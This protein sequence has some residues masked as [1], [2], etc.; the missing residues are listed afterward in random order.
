MF[1]SPGNLESLTPNPSK[2]KYVKP[3]FFSELELKRIATQLR[4]ERILAKINKPSPI[5]ILQKPFNS[6]L[7]SISD[8]SFDQKTKMEE[9]EDRGM[10]KEE[11]IKR[12]EKEEAG[13]KKEDEKEISEWKILN[14]GNM[15]FSPHSLTP[16]PSSS[17]S[18]PPKVSEW[19]EERRMVGN[20]KDGKGE[21]EPERIEEK[22]KN[23]GQNEE[24][25][26][27]ENLK[28]KKKN[29]KEEGEERHEEKVNEEKKD[30][31]EDEQKKSQYFFLEFKGEDRKVIEN[32]EKRIET[33]RQVREIN[34]L[35]SKSKIQR[36]KVIKDKRVFNNIILEENET[37][38]NEIP[39]EKLKRQKESNLPQKICIEHQ[40]KEKIDSNCLKYNKN[41]D[42]NTNN[43]DNQE[44]SF[45]K[46]K[47][48]KTKKY[49]QSKEINKKFFERFLEEN[50]E[51]INY[52][53][54]PLEEKKMEENHKKEKLKK[55]RKVRTMSKYFRSKSGFFQKFYLY[56][57]L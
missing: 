38:G 53:N 14:E 42:E 28:E 29:E 46:K 26:E 32:L 41:N 52:L 48:S 49:L 47:Y 51:I 37:E 35:G 45:D 10:I 40:L 54:E 15:L 2:R 43:F 5:K 21:E 57:L 4:K 31:R 17:F 8:F 25:N 19:E 27:E 20:E 30:K 23:E 22:K 3:Q 34:E 55:E 39:E 44:G 18:L 9:E 16:L 6:A 1:N 36:R 50:K 11:E 12:W 13:G 33:L 56:Y 7:I 24:G